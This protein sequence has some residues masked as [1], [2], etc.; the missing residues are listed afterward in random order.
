MKVRVILAV[1]VAA[2][3]LLAAVAQTASL[4]VPKS[5]AG[6]STMSTGPDALKPAQ[7]A[8]ITLSVLVTGSGTFGNASATANELMLGSATNDRTQGGNGSDCIVGGAGNDTL[9]G[10]GGYDICIG[11]GGTDTFSGCEVTYQ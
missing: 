5:R 7:C 10:G 2:I 8:S 1:L 4:G 11:E 3:A 6:K 9:R